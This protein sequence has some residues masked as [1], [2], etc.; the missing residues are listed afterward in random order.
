M[1]ESDVRLTDQIYALKLLLIDQLIIFFSKIYRIR[2]A[3][4]NFEDILLSLSIV[5]AVF[6]NYEKNR[7][8]KSEFFNISL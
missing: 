2:Q 6:S 7:L 3:R 1:Y 5:E 8:G 4:I